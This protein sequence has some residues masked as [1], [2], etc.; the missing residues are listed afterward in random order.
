M[1]HAVISQD[2]SSSDVERLLVDAR[3]GKDERFGKLLQL[4]RNY[5]T[6]LATTQIDLKLRTR[7]SPS[8]LVQDT[9]L[10]AHRDFHQFR[11]GSEREFLAWLRQILIHCLHHHVDAHVRAK[12][13]DVRREVSLDQFSAQLDRSA[14]RLVH[15]LVDSGRSPSAPARERE[16]AVLLS[17]QLA[18]LRVMLL[19]H[20]SI[21]K[22]VCWLVHVRR[23]LGRRYR[24]A[25][26]RANPA[27]QGVAGRILAFGSR[28]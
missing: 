7:V 15:T 8:D 11:G 26:G 19:T 18:T 13:R 5:L 25:T 4:Y 10:A 24:A 6:V 23:R 2:N 14:Q 16:A 22:V 3:E 21:A 17:D 12:R 1:D 28:P 9:M 27:V 20:Y